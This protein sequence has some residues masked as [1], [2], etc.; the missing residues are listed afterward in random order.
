[1]VN[2]GKTTSQFP[3]KTSLYDAND[4]F[5]F[6]YGMDTS[7]NSNTG[8]SQ[9]ALISAT[10]LFSN[11]SI[12]VVANLQI[13]TTAGDI[14]HSNSLTIQQGTVWATNSYIYVAVANNTVYRASLSS[15]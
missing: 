9:T 12:A 14:S 5:V 3:Q 1:M 6:I 10:S 13:N 7:N 4:V 8:V 2:Q 11:L 15:F